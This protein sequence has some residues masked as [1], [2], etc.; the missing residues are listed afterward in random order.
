MT[1]KALGKHYFEENGP[2]IHVCKVDRKSAITHDFDLTEIE[3]YHDFTELVFILYGKG[4]QVIEGYEYQVSAGDIFVLQ[5]KQKHYFKNL[6]GIQIAN[7]MFDAQTLPRLISNELKKIDGYNALFILEPS[8]RSAHHFKNKLYLKRSKMAKLELI[9]NS[10]LAEQ[11]SQQ[12]GYNILMA[13]HLEEL[14]VLLSRYYSQLETT[15]AQSLLRIGKVID[16]LETHFERKIGLNEM[17]EISF[18]SSRNF[19]RVFKK[20]VGATPLQYLMAIRLQKSR[21]LLRETNKT[22]ASIAAETGF[23]DSNYFIKCFRNANH[24]TPSKFRER[25]RDGVHHNI[26]SPY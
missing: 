1:V 8:Y 23:S 10:M 14:I 16:F 24:I 9:I 13:N 17:S 5:G 22:I 2:A 7:I 11:E 6:F 18:M 25:F 26:K 19:Q 21:Q 12:E 15:E 4:I 3:H 20:A